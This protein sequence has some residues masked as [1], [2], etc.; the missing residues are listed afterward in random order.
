M[1]YRNYY[2]SMT[3]NKYLEYVL[4]FVIFCLSFCDL[5]EC[6]DFFGGYYSYYPEYS[7]DIPAPHHYSGPV[8]FG[9]PMG[10]FSMNGRGPAFGLQAY[11]VRGVIPMPIIQSVSIE[12]QTKFP[13]P[14]EYFKEFKSF[15]KIFQIW[16]KK[17]K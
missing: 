1:F 16:S 11:V 5:I 3:F 12:P 4:I 6:Q 7:H 15:F 13:T 17:R 14:L 9:L 2:P 8:P 10:G